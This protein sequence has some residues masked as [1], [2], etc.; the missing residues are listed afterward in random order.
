MSSVETV[1]ILRSSQPYI[2]NILALEAMFS[3]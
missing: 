2:D 3:H 1:G